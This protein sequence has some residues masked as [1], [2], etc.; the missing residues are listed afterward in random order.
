MFSWFKL[1]KA[2]LHKVTTYKIFIVTIIILANLLFYMYVFTEMHQISNFNY[3]S[4]IYTEVLQY[5][6]IFEI[7]H[8]YVYLQN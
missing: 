4:N 8:A 1:N 5:T 3:H 7:L 2:Y 6:D